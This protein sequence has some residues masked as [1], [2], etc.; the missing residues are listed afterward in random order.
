MQD[1]D[2]T[3]A[4]ALTLTVLM[5]DQPVCMRCLAPAVA[6]QRQA[7]RLVRRLYLIER[8]VVVKW[9]HAREIGLVCSLELHSQA[10]DLSPDSSL[11]FTGRLSLSQEE[12]AYEGP[13]R[14]RRSDISGADSDIPL[15]QSAHKEQSQ[16]RCGGQAPC[17]REEQLI[18]A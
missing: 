18:V 10:G 4:L 5:P 7:D 15:S 11:L 3:A 16:H 17:L 14:L 13:R 8:R 6:V 9:R 12:T 1:I 2:W